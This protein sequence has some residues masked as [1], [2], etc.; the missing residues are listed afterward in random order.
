MPI[1]IEQT[2]ED[3]PNVKRRWEAFWEHALYDRVVI[4]VH[5]P[6]D[7]VTPQAEEVD[8][9]TQWTDAHYMVRRTLESLRSHYYGGDAI[10][11]CWNPI[12]AGHALYF[13]GQ[14]HFQEDTVWVEPAPLGADGY[15]SLEGWCVSP[16]WHLARE[17]IETFAHASRGRFFVLPFWGNHAG[18]ILAMVRGVERFYFDVAE[19]PAWVKA[20]L[21]R[22]SDI[23]IEVHE[24][25]LWRAR[26]EAAGVEGTLNYN[27]CWSPRRTLSFDCDV[28]GNVS[29]QAFRE[30]F[31][32]PL[33]E[34]MAQVDHRIYHLDG[35][36]AARS[37][38]DTLLDLPEL[39]AIQ[40]V[41]GSGHEEI[42]QWLP[43]LKRIQEKGKGIQVGCRPE[44]VELV[45]KE[46][47]PEGL[48]LVVDC[49]SEAQARRLVDRVAELGQS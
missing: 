12:S 44:E 42:A 5:A 41:P 9:V 4:C 7:G 38:L 49:A 39:H 43:M 24:Q 23:L 37:H 26:P 10:P 45:L 6:R 40:W 3:W 32:P 33:L 29:P 48:C 27:G 15:P 11:W 1:P 18:D 2:V 19:N 13:G 46:L 25:L 16:A 20:A 34:S 30:S 22:M 35:P 36:R 14:P 47:K 28:S 21:K 8:A 17:A 31:V